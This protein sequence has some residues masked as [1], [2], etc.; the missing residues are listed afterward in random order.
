MQ[1]LNYTTLRNNLKSVLDSVSEDQDTVIVN[2]GESNVVIVSLKEY[3]SWKET[4][5]LFASKANRDRILKSIDEVE[6]GNIVHHALI[7]D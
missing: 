5:Y 4:E 3:N 2:R 1:V 6:K 7:E